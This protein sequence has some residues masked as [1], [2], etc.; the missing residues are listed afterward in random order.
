[1]QHAG[2]LSLECPHCDTKC[3][4]AEISN[5]RSHCRTDGYFH[6]PYL[7]THCRGV[8]TTKWDVFGDSPRSL[9]IYYPIAGDW[10]PRIKLSSI[11][12]N[13]VREDFI[14]AIGCYN[15]GFYNACMIMARRAIQQE[16]IINE[17]EGDNLYRQIESMGI[18]TNLKA[19]LHKVKN[20]GNHGAHPDF[21]LFGN[22][23][24]KIEDKK[25]FA[26]LSLEF[27]DRYFSDRYEIDAL[28]N[29]AP[30]SKQELDAGS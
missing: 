24:E 8:I 3:Q 23:G 13:E 1:M 2:T 18:S 9:L 7:C 21:H 6:I 4:F 20:F 22:D 5:G 16:M 12:D 19:L 25:L 29:S 30:K 14:E 27:L 17:A 28:A 10:K 26:R 11:K 15:N